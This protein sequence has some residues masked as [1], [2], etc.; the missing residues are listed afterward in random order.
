METVTLAPGAEQAAFPAVP[1]LPARYVRRSRLERRLESGVTAGHVLV[2]APA[3]AGKTLLLAAWA[4]ARGGPIAWVSLEPEDGDPQRFWGRV[5]DAL[6]ASSAPPPG[7]LLRTLQSPPAHD[8]RFLRLL[9]EACDELPTQPV[10]ILDDLHVLK[11]TAAMESLSKAFRGEHAAPPLVLAT[12]SDPPVPMQRLR[13]EGRITELRAADLC[14]AHDEAAQLLEQH[15]VMLSA[16]QLESVLAKTEGWVAGLRLAALALAA[17]PDVAAA[18][19]S[20]A[21]EHR[22][23]ADYFA[24]EV[25][26]TQDEG[27]TDFLL[28]TCVV[29]SLCGDLADALTGRDDGHDMLERLERDNLFVVAMDERREWYRY[30]QMFRDL[31]RHRLRLTDPDRCAELHRRAAQWYVAQGD[32]LEASRHLRQARDWVALSRL[33]LRDAGRNLLGIERHALVSLLEGVPPALVREH[34]E[35]AAAAAVTCYARHDARGVVAH[36]RRARHLL[37]L[38][39]PDDAGLTEAVLT[40]AEAAVAWMESDAP[41]Q[42]AASAEALSRL[43]AIT[44]AELPALPVYRAAAL[45]VR[46]MGQLWSGTINDAERTL[47]ATADAL[48][49]DGALTPVLALHLHG[50]TAVIKAMGGRLREARAEVDTALTIAEQCGWTFMPLSATAYVAE[51]LIRLLEADLD[52]C[53]AAVRRGR[54]CVG[55]LRDR[56]A[57]TVLTLA[58]VRMH[59]AAGNVVAARRCLHELLEST[60]DWSMPRF[61]TQWTGLIE[62]EILMADDRPSQALALLAPRT[63]DPSTRPHA[64][65]VATQARAYLLDRRP[66]DC[67]ASLRDLLQDPPKDRGPASDLWMLAALAHD[68]L[69]HDAEAQLALTRSIA[70]AA[71]EGI[72]RPFV[73]GG[74]RALPLLRTYQRTQSPHREFVARLVTMLSGESESLEIAVPTGPLTNRERSVLMLLPTMMSNAE[75]ADE[76]HVSVN[77]VKVHLKSLYRKLGVTS[78]RQAV[79]RTRDLQ[80]TVGT[81]GSPAPAHLPG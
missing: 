60:A 57:E 7:S 78:R 43:E 58:E 50:S 17:V 69:R 40:T 21:G 73:A 80:L 75:I 19:E 29:R 77:T 28:A 61:L 66:Q 23:V 24:E 32:A 63:A 52:G 30:H 48:Q 51:A 79:A 68:R 13:L 67:L 71:P 25:L 49:A 65:L 33:V 37:H 12:R 26:D 3:G 8:P 39:D 20:L 10:L 47:T 54:T 45:T 81:D 15:D 5:L 55:G 18:V 64:Q 72:C 1:R 38:L 11:G 4:R 42:V 70:I 14:F 16:E 31:L 59:V 74:P 76:L 44:P 22:S 35:A 41:G 6:R 34:P 46:G 53:A 2:S 27:V 62:A 9:V 36:A 56:H